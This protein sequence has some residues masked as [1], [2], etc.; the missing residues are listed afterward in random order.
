MALSERHQVQDSKRHF[1]VEVVSLARSSNQPTYQQQTPTILGD[2][3]GFTGIKC[4][5]AEIAWC[6]TPA[7][8]YSW[9][10]LNLLAF[11]FNVYIGHKN[12]LGET[13]CLYNTQT[14]KLRQE[15]PSFSF[16]SVLI[17]GTQAPRVSPAAQPSPG[18]SAHGQM[19]AGCLHVDV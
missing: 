11:L 18:L 3:W 12:Y 9:T 10:P 16:L 7:I 2:P 14:V 15:I 13:Y 4:R 17:H 5:V 1:Q 19:P 8:C 6:T